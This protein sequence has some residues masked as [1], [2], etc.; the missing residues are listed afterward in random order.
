[1][2]DIKPSA[3]NNQTA[4]QSVQTRQMYAASPMSLFISTLLAAIL[5]VMQRDAVEHIT[6]IIW[7]SLIALVMLAR[8]ALV[9]AYQRASLNDDTDTRVWLTRFRLGVVAAGM[10]WGSAG[11]LLFPDQHPQHQMF[12]IFMLAGLTAGGVVS[13]SADL[14]SGILFSILLIVPLVVRLLLAGDNLSFAMSMAA[15]L[16]LGFML[17]SLR[18]INYNLCENIALRLEAAARESAVRASEERY[19][20]LLSHS[21]VGIFHYDTR[22]VINYC[23]PLLAEIL[24]SSAERITGLDMH[25]LK[26]QSFL[27]ALRRA[28]AGEV[29]YYEGYYR[30]TYSV[31]DGWIA[32]TCAPSQDDSG[33]ITGGIAIVED[34]TTRKQIEESNEENRE[35]FRALSEAAFEAIFIS[36]KGI[37]LEQNLRAQEMFGYTTEE[38]IGKPGTEW[39]APE[40]RDLVIKNMLSGYELPYEITALR[41]NGSTFPASIR[42][43]M[44]HYKGRAVRVTSLRDISEQKQ[45]E[46]DLRIAATAFE[47]REGMLITD[48]DSTILQVNSAF[49]QITGYTPEEVIGKNPRLLNSGLQTADFY[50]TMWEEINRSGSWEGEIWNRRK[51]GEI[52]PEHLTITAVKDKNDNV[53]NYVAALSDITVRK[54]AADEIQNLAYYDPLTRL[55]NRRLLMDRLNQALASSTR[56]GRQGALLFIDLD[57]FKNLND[58]LGHNIGDLLL[59]QVASRLASCVRVGDTVARLGGDEFVVM[60][61]DLN[62]Q[63][64]DAAAQTE[65]VGEKI[66]GT[67][68][69]PYQLASHTCHS[70][71][72]IGATLF[73]NQELTMEDLMKQADIAMY[74]A[75]KAGRNTLRFFDPMMQH[76]INAR[77]T[78]ESELHKALEHH[79]FQLHYQIQV[80]GANCPLG[81]EALIRWLHPDRGMISPAQFI[82]LAE[83]TGLILPIGLWVLETACAR[84]K[85][86][87]E[88]VFTRDLVLAVNVSARQFRQTDFVT[89]VQTVVKNHAINPER[90][91]LELTESLLLENIEETIA[92]MNALNEIGI[93]FSLDDFGTGYSSLQ[94]LKRLPLDQLKIDRSFVRDIASDSSDKAIVRTIIAMAHSLNLDVIAEGVETEDQ[95]QLLINK[96]CTHFQGYLYSMPVPVEQF[97][98]VLKQC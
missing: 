14:L 71:P 86:W 31:A 89:Q 54:A 19:R 17:M 12:L 88:N 79:Q 48:A 34:I 21:P 64:L 39:V 18:H 82:P 13:Y 94:Y 1:M 2:P 75:K 41:K 62:G 68:N 23:N 85:T 9:M 63:A 38:A 20:L 43:R 8:V 56:N 15:L 59:Q 65:I 52:Y 95:Q 25:L 11:F 3:L 42:G 47:S 37:C 58:T 67:L 57:N 76:T 50:T 73:I 80:D 69:Q 77:A 36:E 72:S 44:M 4:I 70:S 49:C 93:Q 60:L 84:L 51:N 81:A 45:A 90:L 46:H 28:L 61:E 40:D 87:E 33:K 24:H 55:P 92:K 32:M 7:F 6:V 83:E 97:E 78:L 74:Q 30:A 96:G 27:P 91:K 29:G 5:A 26:D 22:L 53:T 35:K 98:A 16:Y 66:L 10:V